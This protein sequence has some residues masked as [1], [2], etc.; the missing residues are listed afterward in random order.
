LDLSVFGI[1]EK[2]SDAI[3]GHVPANVEAIKKFP[4]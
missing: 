1:A 4:R 2:I 3:A